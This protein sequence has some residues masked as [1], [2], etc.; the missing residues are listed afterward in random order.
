MQWLSDFL[1]RIRPLWTSGIVDAPSGPDLFAHEPVSTRVRLRTTNMSAAIDYMVAL[2][3][4]VVHGNPEVSRR[5]MLAELG[6]TAAMPSVFT[7]LYPKSAADLWL[8]M[9]ADGDTAFNI[10][11]PAP[12]DANSVLGL[13]LRNSALRIAA[14]ATNEFAGLAAGAVGQRR[15]A[16]DARSADRE[17]PGRRRTRDGDSFRVQRRSDRSL[18][19]SR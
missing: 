10:L 1:P 15:R 18:R 5:A 12:K 2:G 13:L 19:P 4:A 16:R 8:P 14:N 3:D 17:S 6:F 11:A 9:S 7:Q